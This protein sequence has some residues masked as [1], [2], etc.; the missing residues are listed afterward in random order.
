MLKAL[1]Q[2]VNFFKREGISLTAQAE[3]DMRNQLM[4]EARDAFRDGNSKISK[5]LKKENRRI[6]KLIKKR[7]S[8]ISILYRKVNPPP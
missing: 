4:L 2:E 5:F 3:V 6:S 1:S 8:K 7:Y